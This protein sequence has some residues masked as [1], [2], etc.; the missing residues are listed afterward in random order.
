MRELER[1]KD[2]NDGDLPVLAL[3]GAGRVGS[4][5]A[6]ACATAGV[7][8]RLAGREDASTAAA[9]AE[10]VLLC[11][12]DRAI[13][14][15]CETI[16]GAGPKFVGHTSG[17]SGSN[18][19]A[20][21]AARGAATFGFHPLQTVADGTTQL[22]GSACAI[23]GSTPEALD[24]AESL[25]RRLGMRPFEIRDEQ[26][27]AYHA[28][29]SIASN[30]L[31][32]LEESAA[33]LLERSDIADARELLAPLVLRS[34]ANWAERGPDALTGPIARGDEATV[35]RHLDAI[36]DWAPELL[37]LYEALA[38]RTRELAPEHDGALA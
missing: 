34:A 1:E 2:S 13:E 26:R 16:A 24:L 15:A 9:S 7:D 33:Q 10:M 5:L 37:E 32:A 36:G 14:E 11:V 23:S 21:V 30:F 28:A 29:A 6:R 4:T 8:A 38:A 31:V 19:L 12:P 22:A 18:P 25:A 35:R 3:I 17:A 27:A 20:A